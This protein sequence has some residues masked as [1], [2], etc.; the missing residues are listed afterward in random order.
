MVSVKLEH[1]TKKFGDVVAVDD[2]SFN[3]PDRELA[4]IVGPSGCGKTTVLRLIAGLEKPDSG[5]IYFG[6]TCV[7]DVSIRDRRIAMVFQDYALYPHMSVYDN[8]A[9]GLR[10]LG[11]SREEIDKRVKKAAELLDIKHL[12]ERKP[13]QLSGGQRQRVALGR[14]IVRE[15]SV[16]LWDE[17]LSNLDAKMRVLMRAELR[18]L[19]KELKT[20]TIHVT[21]DQLEAMTMAD[22][23]IVMRAGRVEQVG[24]PSEVYDFPA[25]TF[26]AGFIGTPPI[27]FFRASV[28]R[29]RRAVA[30]DAG[31]FSL[32]VPPDVAK[33]VGK[34]GC[35]EV[36]VGV[37]PEDVL[38]AKS[39]DSN[40]V[41]MRVELVE[42]IGSEDLIYLS[43]GDLR[44]VA[45][46]PAKV[47]LKMG[48]KALVTFNIKRIHIFDAKTEKA[49][50]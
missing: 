16:F 32:N 7:N 39:K 40:V 30:L 45:K 2:V 11:Y 33:I 25:N 27:N 24:T 49:I 35:T 47:D 41:E 28:V 22:R 15:P 20:T 19:Q 5:K 36:I 46:G 42:P 14:A 31:E 13:G 43:R 8:M 26:V 34:A 23:V 17:P 37:R 44:F 1:V 50:V 4:V 6:N 38:L 10:N 18:K 9:F 12:L 3:V 48:D 29:K 21:H